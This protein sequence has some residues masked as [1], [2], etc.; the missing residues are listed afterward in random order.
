MSIYGK[1]RQKEHG[2]SGSKL[3]EELRKIFVAG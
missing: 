3:A 1:L 2:C